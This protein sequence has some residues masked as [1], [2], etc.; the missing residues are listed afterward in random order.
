MSFNDQ[1]LT[2]EGEITFVPSNSSKSGYL[3]NR[4]SHDVL[5]HYI[6]KEKFDEII[7]TCSKLLFKNYALRIEQQKSALS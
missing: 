6:S 1:V 3:R 4:Y 5:D 7:D 2:P